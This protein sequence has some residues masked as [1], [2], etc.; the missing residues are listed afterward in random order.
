MARH[1]HIRIQAR[2]ITARLVNTRDAGFDESKHPRADD[3]KFGAGAGKAAQ[4]GRTAGKSD[5]AKAREAELDDRRD[6]EYAKGKTEKAARIKLL[7]GRLQRLD[8]KAPLREKVK[9]V[10]ELESLG[11][12]KPRE[13]EPE[14]KPEPKKP[15]PKVT[16]AKSGYGGKKPAAAGNAN[17]AA[18]ALALAKR[19]GKQADPD[20]KK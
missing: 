4:S 17:E 9:I 6:A 20:A 8:A 5:Y 2:P 13:P 16:P 12:K 14:K 18:Q 15:D 10:K 1:I 3:G 19:L 11:W 7:E